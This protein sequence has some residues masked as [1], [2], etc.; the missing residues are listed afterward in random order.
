MPPAIMS[1]STMGITPAAR[2]GLGAYFAPAPPLW[3]DPRLLRD[4]VA[5]SGLAEAL[6]SA[7]AIVMRANGVRGLS[8]VTGGEDS[9]AGGGAGSIF[10]IVWAN[11]HQR[12]GEVAMDVL[13]PAGLLQTPDAD[14]ATYELDELQRIFL[15]ARAD[16]IY[17]GSDEVQKN[18]LAERVLGLPREARP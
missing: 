8:M 13:G 18:I 11:W 5:A 7:P 17:G 10:K 6:G 9:A 16:T 1:L 12:L 14:P 4:T 15:F 3:N 2:H